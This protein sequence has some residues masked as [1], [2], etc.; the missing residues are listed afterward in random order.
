MIVEDQAEK[1]YAL[2]DQYLSIYNWNISI[3]LES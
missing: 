2:C 1:K 3:F